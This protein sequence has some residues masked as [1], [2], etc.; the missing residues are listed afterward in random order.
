MRGEEE[1]SEE[2]ENINR[3]RRVSYTVEHEKETGIEAGKR[4][5]IVEDFGPSELIVKTLCGERVKR[6]HYDTHI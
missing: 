6:I 4:K 2:G 3:H 1:E 5:E